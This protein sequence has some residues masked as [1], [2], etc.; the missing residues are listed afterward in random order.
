MTAK[1]S[2]PVSAEKPAVTAKAAA[3]STDATLKSGAAKKTTAAAAKKPAAVKPA[4]DAAGLET[5]LDELTEV[6]GQ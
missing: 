4:G 2:A 3:S 5:T 1:K 6:S